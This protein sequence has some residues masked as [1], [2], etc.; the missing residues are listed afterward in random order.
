VA[1]AIAREVKGALTPSQ[2]SRL[3]QRTPID[4]AVYDLYLRGRH[5]WNL[6]ELAARKPLPTSA[7]A[8]WYA[9]TDDHRAALD[10]LERA[11]QAGPNQFQPLMADPV[12]DRLRL[13]T[14]FTELMRRASRSWSTPE[15]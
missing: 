12:F 9:A 6:R 5:A 3:A 11:L 13:D 10:M 15:A 4:P 7:L 8:R 14:R 1:T 2:Q